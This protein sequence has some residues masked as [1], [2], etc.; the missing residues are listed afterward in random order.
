M[1]GAVWDLESLTTVSITRTRLTR[2]PDE[3]RSLTHVRRLNLSDNELE[4]FPVA[5]AALEQL[6]VLR[7]VG[8]RFRELPSE[9]G[10]LENLRELYLDGNRLR[11]LPESIGRLGRLEVLGLSRNS[12]E[13]LPETLADLRRLRVLHLS[14]NR[15]QA[16][17]AGMATLLGLEELTVDGNMLAQIPGFLGDLPELRVL[18]TRNNEVQQLPRALARSESLQDLRLQGNPLAEPPIE[19]AERGLEAVR[20]YLQDGDSGSVRRWTSR[21]IVIGDSRAG[22]TSLLRGLLGNSFQEDLPSTHGI[23]V[24]TLELGPAVRS[25]SPMKLRCWDFGGQAIYHATHQ[26]FLSPSCLFLLAW[27]PSTW[28]E[29]R[30]KYWLEILRARFPESPVLLVATHRDQLPTDAAAEGLERTYDQVCGNYFVSNKNLAGFEDL[31]AGIEREAS[32]LPLMGKRW[33]QS[34]LLFAEDI[35][36]RDAPYFKEQE[37]RETLDLHGITGES[38]KV[39]PEWLTELGEILYFADDHRLREL[40]VRD[41]QWLSGLIA[42][43]LMS[44][45]VSE[46]EGYLR[47]ETIDRLWPDVSTSTRAALLSLMERFDLACRLP[48][49]EERKLL[50][51]EKLPAK[52]PGYES[53]WN[54]L[55][56]GEGVR[57]IRMRFDFDV[58]LPAGLPTWF[59]ARSHRFATEW[60]W[61][62]GGLF[63]DNDQ[64]GHLAL[65]EALPEQ[66]TISLS[67]RGPNPVSF[68]SVLRDGLEVTFRRYPALRVTRRVPCSG[69]GGEPCEHWFNYV[70]L[71]RSL[72]EN[73]PVRHIECP[74]GQSSVDIGGLVFGIHWSTEGQVIALMERVEERSREVLTELGDARDDII[75]SQSLLLEGQ[76]DQR[77][78]LE[79]EFLKRLRREQSRAR[80]DCPSVFL[81]RALGTQPSNRAR[82]LL[83]R[84]LELHLCC[85]AP[86]DWHPTESG[87]RYVLEDPA[88]WIRVIEPHIRRLVR[89]LRFVGPLVGPVT[90]YAGSEYEELARR[91]VQ[92][93]KAL[94]D[95]L[96]MSTLTGA[97]SDLSDSEGDELTELRGGSLRG[98][99]RMLDALDPGRH[100]GDLR[101]VPTPE[102]PWLW[103]CER[104][105]EKYLT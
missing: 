6:E 25:G 73:P 64:S 63:R 42:R 34:W 60:L 55:Q 102:G 95:R 45:A 15:L 82:R 41:P 22:K 7:I 79:R 19:L 44:P 2:V 98:L 97:D 83:A 32:R 30:L 94:I 27:K 104:H 12:L 59:L 9:I 68:F 1:P 69:H 18:D 20:A 43:V 96:P 28:S 72:T 5:I 46:D 8:N 105:E 50:V 103:L 99:E 24:S 48:D 80:S 84:K 13:S 3:I 4:T 81:L 10:N 40:V 74:V 49:D 23:E 37:L 78:F 61:R 76:R 66:R 17:P 71:E 89:I 21:L 90:A 58:E 35:A 47:P 101:R 57:E 26:F 77:K 92:F 93:M 65:V 38:R 62:D 29:T 70:D 53:E 39:L 91:D 33:P 87:G 86:G 16:L 31:V 51:V 52:A 36:G 67:V 56:V 85:E 100:W 75:H 14:D 54:Q 11:S 88:K